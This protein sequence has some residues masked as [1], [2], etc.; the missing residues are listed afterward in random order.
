MV[1]S[2]F[3]KDDKKMVSEFTMT[4][5]LVTKGENG[6]KKDR[7]LEIF[8]FEGEWSAFQE[9]A[10]ANPDRSIPSHGLGLYLANLAVSMIHWRIKPC[11]DLE[12]GKLSFIFE[13]GLE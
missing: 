1:N 6:A 11:L 13:G 10:R 2:S 8:N 3:D 7:W 9:P 4:F 5:P 12:N